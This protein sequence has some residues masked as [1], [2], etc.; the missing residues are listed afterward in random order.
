MATS[1]VSQLYLIPNPTV[2]YLIFPSTCFLTK[3]LVNEAVMQP[4]FVF[5]I[6]LNQ[7]PA[8]SKCYLVFNAIYS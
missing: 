4:K 8:V 2:K 5:W 6:F 7:F 3:L 1:L